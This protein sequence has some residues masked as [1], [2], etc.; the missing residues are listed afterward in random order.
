MGNLLKKLTPAEEYAENIYAKVNSKNIKKSQVVSV[1]K[2][3]YDKI[4][5]LKTNPEKINDK[6]TLRYLQF[7][8]LKLK[9]MIENVLYLFY[10]LIVL[11][12]Y[13]HYYLL[14]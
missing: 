10:H 9:N 5:F 12:Q 8:Y 14:F 3:Y 1:A 7:L 4:Q 13:N 11:N 2:T 6:N